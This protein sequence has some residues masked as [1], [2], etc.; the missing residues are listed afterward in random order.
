VLRPR[1]HVTEAGI[2]GIGL[3]PFGVHLCHF[4]R[5]RKELL[6]GLVPY[7]AAGLRNNERCIWITAPPLAAAEAAAELR[8]EVPDLD[9]RLKEGAIRILD[10]DDPGAPGGDVDAWLQEEE[11]ALA[12][13]REGLRI[14]GNRSFLVRGTWD[15]FMAH[16]SAA[17]HAFASRRVVALCSYD[18]FRCQATDVFEVIRRHPHTLDQRD[19]LW[20]V[21]EGPGFRVVEA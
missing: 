4:Y 9:R 3:I 10:H 8:K 14:S 20:E 16:E 2:P 15:A 11:K 12:E 21:L 7:F 1:S 17:T 19:G 18:I 5:K 6:D 13:G